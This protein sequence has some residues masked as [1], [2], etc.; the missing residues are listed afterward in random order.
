MIKKIA[1]KIIKNVPELDYRINLKKLTN[2]YYNFKKMPSPTS[3]ILY[4]TTLC[5]LRCKHCFYSTEL[6]NHKVF[7]SLEE[8]KKTVNSLVYPATFTLTGGEPFLRK[9][10]KEIISFIYKKFKGKRAIM[11]CTNGTLHKRIY[12]I[13]KELLEKYN[14]LQLNIEI[15]IDGM[16]ETHNT[17]R[18]EGSFEK[19][20]ETFKLMKLLRKKYPNNLKLMSLTAVQK[21]NLNDIPNILK[22]CEKYKLDSCIQLTRSS[23]FGIVGLPREVSNEVYPLDKKSTNLTVKELEKLFTNIK[24]LNKYWHKM[25]ILSLK[26]QIKL[27]KEKK[28][29]M[30]CGAGYINA[31]IYPNGDVSICELTKPIGNLKDFNFNFYTLWHSQQANY[32]RKKTRNCACIHGCNIV[33]NIQ[34]DKNL[35]KKQNI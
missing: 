25:N 28:K 20:I 30:D 34:L 7:M 19:V 18:G 5:N 2:R 31:I 13:S 8:I 33:T 27:I 17:I 23:D 6:N 12:N 14:N 29:T 3:I 15:S 21:D 9:D 24:R 26:Y 32:M 35:F 4:V 16:K 22:F 11:I 1:K 10:I